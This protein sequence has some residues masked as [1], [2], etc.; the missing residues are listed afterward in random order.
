MQLEQG[1]NMNSEFI[2]VFL[3]SFSL[4]FALLL[5]VLLENTKK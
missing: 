1:G 4:Y 2:V 5:L 3:Y